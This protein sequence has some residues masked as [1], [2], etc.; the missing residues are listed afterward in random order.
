MKY[1]LYYNWWKNPRGILAAQN[2]NTYN[3]RKLGL[4][5]A[6]IVFADVT[7]MKYTLEIYPDTAFYFYYVY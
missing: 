2:P 7:K 5:Q 1:T 6:D 4:I 3:L